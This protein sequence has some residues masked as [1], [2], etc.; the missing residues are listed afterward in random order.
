M[1]L[2]LLAGTGEARQIAA[3]LAAR[4]IPATASLAGATREPANLP[5]PTRIGG[6]GGEDGF[7]RYLEAERITAILDATHPFAARIT[8]RSARIAAERGLP[9]L[10]LDRPEWRPGPA[11]R[12]TIIHREEEAEAHLPAG[13]TVFLATGRQTLE[14]FANLGGRRV[15]CRRID[16]PKGQFPLKNGRYIVG[17]PPFSLDEETALFRAL[18]IDAI[19]VKNAGGTQ[20]RAKLD[21][22]RDLGLPVLVIA[23][24][25]LPEAPTVQ[26]V[27][28]ALDWAEATCV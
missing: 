14:R 28:A 22:A 26:T 27:A 2:L 6:F 18:K 13:A 17:K 11:D 7:R 1:T 25:P 16:P 10:Y 12:W 23:R 4:R 3:G 21:A 8:A 24:P 19:V 20:A 15:Y 9:Y 5:V